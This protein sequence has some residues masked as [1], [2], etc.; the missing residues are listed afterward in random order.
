LSQKVQ[1][2]ADRII[3][4]ELLNFSRRDVGSSLT[5]EQF[6]LAEDFLIVFYYG[7]II[8]ISHWFYFQKLEGI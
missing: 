5:D 8:L 4:L 7:K 1:R 3:K 2:E 6:E